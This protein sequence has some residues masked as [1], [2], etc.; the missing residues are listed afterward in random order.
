MSL[1]LLFFNSIIC[2]IPISIA[3]SAL[4]TLFIKKYTTSLRGIIS[5][6]IVPIVKIQKNIKM[7]NKILEKMEVKPSIGELKM[8]RLFIT[9][10]K[11]PTRM[12]AKNFKPAKVNV[13]EWRSAIVNK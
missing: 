5:K 4:L 8:L 3:T 11:I 6:K 2:P 7:R 12:I 10:I 1:A 9:Q 13:I